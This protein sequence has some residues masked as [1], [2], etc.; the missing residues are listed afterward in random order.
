MIS[1]VCDEH[2]KA[3]VLNGLRS[4]GFDIVTFME[5]GRKSIADEEQIQWARTVG[6]V[7]LTND[8]DYL[9]LA[10]ENNSDHSGIMFC[11]AEKHSIGSM[12]DAVERACTNKAADAYHGQTVFL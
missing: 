10:S 12:I 9:K 6:R 1:I 2:I 4:R 3:A 7:I 8:D 5:V 11:H